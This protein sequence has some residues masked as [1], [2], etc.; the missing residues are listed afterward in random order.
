[1]FGNREPR[2]TKSSKKASENINRK[3]EKVGGEGGGHLAW[4]DKKGGG[5]QHR[6][7]VELNIKPKIRG[8][9]VPEILGDI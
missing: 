1:L 6:E 4:K 8:R 7:S 2:R 3:E 9:T 5:L